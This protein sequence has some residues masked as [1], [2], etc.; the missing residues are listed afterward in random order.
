MIQ[1]VKI[2]FTHHV[3]GTRLLDKMRGTWGCSPLS[4]ESPLM[5]LERRKKDGARLGTQG[6]TPT[7]HGGCLKEQDGPEGPV[8]RRPDEGP[9]SPT[10]TTAGL[11]SQAPRRADRAP[12][13]AAALPVQVGTVTGL[14]GECPPAQAAGGARSWHLHQCLI[15]HQCAGCI[16][17]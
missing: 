10:A 17:S 12:R 2:R 8:T 11:P 15:V 14:K 16:N 3:P 6:A 9:S 5:H 13:R 4:E 1:F 7:W